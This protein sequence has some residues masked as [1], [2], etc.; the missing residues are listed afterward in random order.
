LIR[1]SEEPVNYQKL[2]SSPKALQRDINYSFINSNFYFGIFVG[3]ILKGKRVLEIGPGI[4]LGIPLILACYGA[5]IMAA[6]R[7]LPPW[8]PD[9]H[10]KFY[11]LLRNTL[12]KINCPLIDLTPVDNVI[13]QGSYPPESIS[14]YSCSLEEL[15]LIPDQC[16]DVVISNA[17]LEHLF[18]IELAFQHLARITKFGGL[19]IHQV[20]FRDHLDFAR[21]LEYL[22]LSNEE[23]SQM[24]SK[25][26]GEQGNRSRPREMRQ[27]F[28]VGGFEVKI[29]QPN[30]FTT[31]EYLNEFLGRLRQAS[32]SRYRDYPAE[33]LRF[34]SG[35]FY[36]V[37]KHP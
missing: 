15:S 27:L 24:L 12:D 29:F 19:G 22:L 26:H 1:G 8:D 6:E 23:F 3:E 9:Y 37:K 17:V 20:D 28:E 7:F 4:N 31:D 18:D 35:L 16:V 36:V 21:P 14:L 30:I 11:S 13:S 2:D 25:K 33:D 10:P 34:L 5:E 32:T